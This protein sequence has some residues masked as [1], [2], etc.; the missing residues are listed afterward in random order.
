MRIWLSAASIA[1]AA[2]AAAEVVASGSG[3]YELRHAGT[4]ELAPDAM[5]ERLLDVGSWW[6]DA[7]TYSGSAANLS[8]DAQAGGLWREDWKGGSVAHG[9]VLLVQPPTADTPG[10]LRLDAPFGPLQERDARVVWTITVSA[11]EDGSEV[12]FSEVASGSARS[13]L[14]TLAPAVDFVK[15]KALEALLAE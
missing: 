1:L 8:L 6:Q 4:S 15:G 3:H 10:T 14:D 5:W 13:G 2:P 12:S 9:T 11:H 7:H